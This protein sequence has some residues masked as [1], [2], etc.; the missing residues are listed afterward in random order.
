MKTAPLVG[1]TTPHQN[2][3]RPGLWLRMALVLTLALALASTIAAGTTEAPYEDRLVEVALRQAHASDWKSVA[4]QPTAVKALLLD[5]DHE[6]AFKAQLALHKYGDA[7]QEVLL[8][9]G[10]DPTFQAV[11]RQYGENTLPVIAYF[12]KNDL[13]SMRLLYLA[14]QKSEVAIAAAKDFWA[15]WWPSVPVESSSAA[16]YKK[17]PLPATY[18]P[19]LR[20]QRAIAFIAHDGYQFLGQ[21]VLDPQ[22]QAVWVQTERGLGAAKSLFFSGAIGLEK[23]YKSGQPLEAVD[24]L[25]AGM[26]VFIVVGAFKAIKFL[27]AAREVRAVGVVQRTQLLGAPLLRR[28]ALGRYVVQYGAIAGT[29]YLVVRHPSLLSSLWV[30]WGRWLGLSPFLA[31]TIGWGVL[32]APLLLPLLSLLGLALSAAGTLLITTSKGLRWTQR[33]L[34]F[35]PGAA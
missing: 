15:Q 5:Y 16:E 3:Q 25:S 17:A 7:A 32:L 23:K 10:D 19:D 18:G 2:I 27:R 11:L 21:F 6:L 22:G 1:D 14:Q 9:F 20:G 8:R 29:V 34:G 4:A 28:S 30:T 24:V 13:A 26:D 33:R 35:S 31:K 12:V